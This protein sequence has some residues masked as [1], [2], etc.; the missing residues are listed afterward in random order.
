VNYRHAFHAGNFAD[1]LKH[2][3]LVRVLLHLRT[4]DAAFRLVETHAG[5]GRYDLQGEAA[6]H[7]REWQG[8]IG[9]LLAKSLGREA[10]EVIEPYLA[11]VRGRNV[12]AEL[13]SYPGSP[14]I[15]LALT[16]LQDRLV[17]HELHPEEYAALAALVGRG[18]RARAVE[19]DGW[20]ALK[21]EL[22]P[23]ERRGCVLL[24]PP[25]EEP[26]EFARLTESLA[27]AYRRWATGIY[28]LWYPIKDTREVESFARRVARLGIPKILRVELA[29]GAPATDQALAACGILAVNPP[30]TLERDLMTLLPALARALGRDGAGSHRLEWIAP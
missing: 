8:G 29:V 21:A 13:K 26:G 17:F 16:R 2:A 20:A 22:P 11:V 1:V 24:D 19:S 9:R 28:L 12:G 23:P 5:A 4:K 15:A 10:D 7:T 14:L 25:F 30:W 6:N 18:N 27:Q 3:V